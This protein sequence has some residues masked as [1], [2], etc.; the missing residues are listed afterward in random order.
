MK[1]KTLMSIVLLAIIGT[2][3]VFAQQPTMDK[4]KISGSGSKGDVSAAYKSISGEVVI[5]GT[6]DKYSETRAYDFRDCTQITS[7]IMLEGTTDIGGTTF[8]GCTSLTSVIIPAS[9]T[10]ID[11]NAFQGCDNLTSVTFGS[12]VIR[13]F[14]DNAFP[15]DLAKVFKSGAGGAGTF[16]RD[17][18]GTTWTKISSTF[19]LNGTWTRADGM[20]INITDNG[21]NITIT[22]DKPNNGGKLNDT[23]TKK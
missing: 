23:Y 21:A 15:G 10:R 11:G 2:S 12:N 7:V 20:K 16:I 5:P 6:Y 4:L 1:K 22:G 13:T 14:Y 9:M 8:R 18:G 3:A 19:T 17:A